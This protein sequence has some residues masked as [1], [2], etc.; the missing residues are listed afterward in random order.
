MPF[1]DGWRT[2]LKLSRSI[3]GRAP[4][5]LRGVHVFTYSRGVGM[6]TSSKVRKK[7]TEVASTVDSG[8]RG[9]VG[10][11]VPT[12]LM[13]S[14][15]F[16]RLPAEVRRQVDEAILLRPPDCATL[17]AIAAKYKLKDQY[18]VSISALKAYARNL[19]R[20][21]RPIVSS[22]LL[23]QVLGCLPE[24]HRRGLVAG[25]E[26]LLLSRVFQSL[27]AETPSALSVADLAKLAS[28]LASVGGK[29]KAKSEKSDADSETAPA[30]TNR[31]AEAVHLLYGLSWP[32]EGEAEGDDSK[33]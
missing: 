12:Q 18:Q 3:A 30:D 21:A 26:V 6:S 32:P 16:R 5:Y 7:K 2:E 31:L 15:A 17:E 22:R 4:C 20:L 8:S 14:V 23:S 13:R 28:V 11:S 9:S 19:E 33:K 24:Q 29:S 10:V 27:S 1:F 25:G